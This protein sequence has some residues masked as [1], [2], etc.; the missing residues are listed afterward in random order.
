VTLPLR[1]DERAVIGEYL[2][3]AAD[4][5][6][7]RDWMINLEHP[8]APPEKGGTTVA[9]YGRLVVDIALSSEF[10]SFEPDAQRE[11]LI[12][13]LLHVRRQRI[14][15][16]IIK[17]LPDVMGQPA[18][19]VFYEAFCQLDEEATDADATSIASSFRRSSSPLSRRLKARRFR[20]R[21]PSSRS[22]A[23][24]SPRGDRRVPRAAPA[25]E[26]R[27]VDRLAGMGDARVARAPART[28]WGTIRF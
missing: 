27:R 1:P 19:S 4:K 21:T 8:P 15:W 26:G 28:S 5:L 17:S 7:M 6:G 13:E 18:Y 3:S 22:G 24:R 14:R 11:T 16:L 10:R 25:D 2:R 12:H 23:I 20:C 9:Y